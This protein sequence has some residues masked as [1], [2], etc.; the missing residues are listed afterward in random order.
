MFWTMKDVCGYTTLSE[1]GIR[2]LMKRGEF[3][4]SHSVMGRK[5]VWIPE[6]V[7]Q[8]C[9]KR[10]GGSGSIKPEKPSGWLQSW[11]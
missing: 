8:W 2:R 4:L 7:Q 5:K 1:S 11:S 9:V 6:E 10:V 3:P